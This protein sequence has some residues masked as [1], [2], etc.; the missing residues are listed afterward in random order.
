VS[1]LLPPPFTCREGVLLGQQLR[2]LRLETELEKRKKEKRR[3]SLSVLL[4][5]GDRVGT[6]LK[7]LQGVWYAKLYKCVSRAAIHVRMWG[8]GSVKPCLVNFFEK[9]C[10]LQ[11]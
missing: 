7:G 3:L 9:S 2:I 11:A 10:G 4:V 5:K 1:P 8:Q 6:G